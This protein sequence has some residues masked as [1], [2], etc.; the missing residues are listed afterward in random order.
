MVRTTNDIRHVQIV[1][2]AKALP[3][4]THTQ[5]RKGGGGGQGKSSTKYRIGRVFFAVKA[6]AIFLYFV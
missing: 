2:I 1:Q 4:P 3:D 6:N 5:E